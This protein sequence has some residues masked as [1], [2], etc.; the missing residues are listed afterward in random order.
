MSVSHRIFARDMGRQALEDIVALSVHA[1]AAEVEPVGQQG[2]GPLHIS[3]HVL[4]HRDAED[5]YASR[6]SHLCPRRGHAGP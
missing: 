3:N 4:Q 1:E 6:L 5:A 2:Q